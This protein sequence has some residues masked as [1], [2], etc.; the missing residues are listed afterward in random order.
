MGVDELQMDEQVVRRAARRSGLV[1][2]GF[3][4]LTVLF[5]TAGFVIGASRADGR[6]RS[7][8]PAILIIA[9][10]LGLAALCLWA[11]ARA[12]RRRGLALTSPLWGVDRATRTRIVRAI[13]HRQE[14]TGQDREIALAEAHRSRK[15]AS[16]AI[17]ALLVL[18]V[19]ILAGSVLALIGD[20]HPAQ[21]AFSLV[22]LA[23]IGALAAHQFVFYR[24]A[25]AY[26]ERFGA[27]PGPHP[28]NP[29]ATPG[30]P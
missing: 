7:P 18:L 1:F 19:L 12:I 10:V 26:L 14:L 15:L 4:L 17:T 16:I 2:W 13:K 23:L 29:P 6:S 25:G 5:L 27:P 8:L 28:D 30:S 11:F 9:G 21:L 3:A 22:Q 20:V 24:R